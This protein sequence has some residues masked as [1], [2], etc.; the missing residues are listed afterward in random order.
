LI[1]A[2]IILFAAVQASAA[3]YV[4]PDHYSTIQAALNAATAGDTIQVRQQG[5]PYF[6]KIQFPNSGSAGSGSITLEAFPGDLPVIDGTG[7]S[8]SNIVLIQN[9][10]YVKLIG[11]EIR[12]NLNVNDGSGVRILGSGSNI[13]I[14]NNRIHDVRGSHAMGITVYGTAATPISNLIIDGNEIY[15]CEPFRSEALTL[16]GNVTDF[17]VTNNIVRDVNNIGIDFIGGE[18]DIQ[19]DPTKVARNGVCRGNQVF[20]AKEQG[21]GYAGCIYVDGGKD[22]VIENNVASGCDLGI[23]IGAENS[24]IVTS[25]IIVRDNLV[26]DNEKVGIVFG[27]FKASVGRVKN[28]QFLNNTLYKNDTLGEG[29]G[30][31]W[32]QFAEDNQVR[33]NI[34]YST[35]QNVLVYS[36]NGNVN[37]TLDYNLFFTDSGAANAEL[38]WQNTSYTGF[39]AYKAGTGQDA[40]SLFSNPLFAD[41][42]NAD[43]H[44][45]P[46]S[47]AVNQGDPSFV[48]GTGEV[49]IDQTPRLDGPRVDMG[50]DEVGNCGNGSVD[51]GEQC[52]DAANNGTAS[53][54]C[55]ASCLFKPNGSASCDGNDCTRP[56]IC[57]NGVCTPGVC[58]DGNACTFCG[59]TCVD[60]GG[61]C[62]CQ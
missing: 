40:H 25:G 30:E 49:D 6:E 35:S 13:E 7:V 47:P 29:L 1:F 26:Y 58:A 8:G 43:F 21:G 59:G 50:A 28:S 14:R 56:D 10:S 60:G 22:I 41:A 51:F 45:A 18:T 42:P 5:T 4:V 33:N 31:L 19:P 3:T 38:V 9:K 23:E 62:Q 32:I 52:D 11:F 20:R 53:S 37:N 54:C 24:G 44:V 55:A 34:L 27:G 61:S 57:T 12:N 16:N 46:T 39:A 15:D 2:M 17:A 48:A 36:E